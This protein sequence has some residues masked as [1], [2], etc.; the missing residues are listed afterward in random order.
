MIPVSDITAKYKV[1]YRTSLSAKVSHA[2]LIGLGHTQTL[3]PGVKLTLSA[4]IDGRNFNAGN[5]K[6]GSGFELRSLMWF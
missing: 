3:C 1:T 6:V 5:H 2:S 4:L